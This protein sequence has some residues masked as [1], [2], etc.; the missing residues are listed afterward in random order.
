MCTWWI[1]K[2]TD[3]GLIQTNIKTTIPPS[4]LQGKQT[5]DISA[6]RLFTRI[7]QIR[8]LIPGTSWVGP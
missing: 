2:E 3:C 6:I 1:M 4:S 7:D 8:V 5:F